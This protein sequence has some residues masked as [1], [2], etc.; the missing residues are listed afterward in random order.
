MRNMTT[1]LTLVTCVGAETLLGR[2][3]GEAHLPQLL[4]A[5]LR[6]A[7]DDVIYLDFSG[8]TNI[9]ASYIAAAIVPLLR[10]VAAGSLGRYLII[11]GLDAH[12][13]EEL[14][15]VLKHEHTPVLQRTSDGSFRVLGPLDDAYAQTLDAVIKRGRVTARELHKAT[16]STIGQTGWIKRLTTLHDLGLVKKAKVGREFAYDSLSMEGSHG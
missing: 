9:T 4:S 15:Y 6:A 14:A 12:C 8:I 7:P 11:G 16:T 2:P 13:E 3:M 1:T 10:M 5:I